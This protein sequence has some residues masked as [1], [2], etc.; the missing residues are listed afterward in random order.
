MKL[1]LCLEDFYFT[2]DY[3]ILN[4]ASVREDGQHHKFSI[5]RKMEVLPYI[6]IRLASIV[7]SGNDF[8]KKGDDTH[9]GTRQ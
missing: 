9:N 2:L 3:C 4:A 7:D 5:D 1:L 8:S 6:Q